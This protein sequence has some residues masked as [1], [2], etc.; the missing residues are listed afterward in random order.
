MP[1]NPDPKKKLRIAE[2]KA[3]AFKAKDKA[4]AKV[5]VGHVAVEEEDDDV[6]LD[7][8]G[9]PTREALL[10]M[11]GF[12]TIGVPIDVSGIDLLET[13]TQ[14]KPRKVLLL[15]L[16]EMVPVRPLRKPSV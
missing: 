8:D 13:G 15:A 2:A 4:K 5:A 9:K 12:G 10:D 16:C 1:N 14:T 7:D 3:K 11:M 6:D